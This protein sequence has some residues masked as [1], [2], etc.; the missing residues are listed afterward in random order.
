MGCLVL[1]LPRSVGVGAEGKAC[2]MS[3][4]PSMLDTVFTSA[5]F[6]R[7]VVAEGI[8]IRH[9]YHGGVLLKTVNWLPPLADCFR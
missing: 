3:W 5:L 9:K 2:A 8:S 4:W 7:A 6:C 1:L